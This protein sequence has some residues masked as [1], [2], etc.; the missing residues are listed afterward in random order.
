MDR[1]LVPAG[2]G[3][4]VSPPRNGRSPHERTKRATEVSYVWCE[5]HSSAPQDSAPHDWPSCRPRRCVLAPDSDGEPWPVHPVR[6]RRANLV[7]GHWMGCAKQWVE[8]VS[9]TPTAAVLTL[10]GGARR[11]PAPRPRRAARHAARVPRRRRPGLAARPRTSPPLPMGHWPVAGL[12]WVPNAATRRRV[13]SV[14]AVRWRCCAPRGRP[15]ASV[16]GHR[17]ATHPTAVS[18]GLLAGRHGIRG[19]HSVAGTRGCGQPRIALQFG[20][21]NEQHAHDNTRGEVPSQ[22]SGAAAGAQANTGAGATPHA[23]QRRVSGWRRHTRQARQWAPAGG[24]ATATKRAH[25]HRRAGRHWLYHGWKRRHTVPRAQHVGP[26]CSWP[27]HCPH[28]PAHWRRG[29]RRRPPP[30]GRHWLYH[31]WK[32]RHAVPRAQHVGPA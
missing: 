15:L 19:H 30:A 20:P 27:P 14:R 17:A 3:V 1:W 2:A 23:P 18:L 8:A 11:R 31:G 9:I 22:T 32:R 10:R 7:T 12:L 4:G 28:R 5:S 16:D 29:R 25:A 26:A 24:A 6:D 13:D 21:Q